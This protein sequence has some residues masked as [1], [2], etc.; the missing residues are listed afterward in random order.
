MGVYGSIL[1]EQRVSSSR[2]D[3]HLTVKEVQALRHRGIRRLCHVKDFN[4]I[5]PDGEQYA[6][7]GRREVVQRVEEGHNV[8]ISRDS[9]ESRSVCE[10]RWDVRGRIGDCGGVDE[11]ESR[12]GTAVGR[13]VVD[14]DKVVINSE[15]AIPEGAR[16]ER[17]AGALCQD[18]CVVLE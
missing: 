7:L 13:E 5:P 11:E 6:S 18:T 4:A 16:Y 1:E 15:F 9:F 12:G 3:L 10:R 14:Q 2:N 8:R 17:A